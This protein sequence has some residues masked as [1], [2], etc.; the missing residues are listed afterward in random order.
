MDYEQLWNNVL[1]QIGL[2]VSRVNF[3]TWFKN[4]VIADYKDGNVAV[5]VP[6]QFVKEWLEG[7]YT[8]DIL[9]ILRNIHPSI[10]SVT[11]III[12]NENSIKRN[13]LA[14]L[15]TSNQNQSLPLDNISINKE[16]NLN[17]KYSFDNYIIGPFNDV[18]YAAASSIMNN[19]GIS[20]NPFFVYGGTGL[21]KTH[22]LQS[23][24]N[25]VK[26][27]YPEKRIFYT[28]FERFYTDY[29]AST[30]SNS[31]NKFKDKY[32]SYDVLIM[33][34]IQFITNKDKTQ[35]ELFHIFNIMYENNRQI[36][37]S[38]DVHPNFIV[39]L[40]ERLRSRFNHGMVVDI[41]TP[42]FESR[43]A[44]L[45][46]KTKDYR[47]KITD[48]VLE[49]IAQNV[50][51]NIRE[52]EGIITNILT[53]TEVRNT[54][55]NINDIKTYLKN[56]LKNKKNISIPDI[57]KVIANYYSITDD[58]VYNKTR[59]K[60]IIKPRQI[61]M[62]LLRED[63]DISYPVIGEKLGGRDHTTVIHSYEKIKRELQNDPKLAKE[64]DEIRNML[65]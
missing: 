49:F 29:V 34:D 16:D 32:R 17:P 19:P 26:K 35:D 10:R 53:L 30:T 37:F 58:F 6:N 21:G 18:A 8:K 27:K 43:L 59:R 38:A 51:C 4:S 2:E 56:N 48:E 11:F 40:E 31:I 14:N 25:N 3:N 23:V 44:I 22:L 64:I 15:N 20:Y 50:N 47:N 1:T 45:Q 7:K 41:E 65:G 57:V 39:G 60:D 13:N 46:S 12:K 33:D 55:L 24:G 36:I 42:P 28:S 9:R 62:F 61:I 52:L 5:G 54:I 63:Y